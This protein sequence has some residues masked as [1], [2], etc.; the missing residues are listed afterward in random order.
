MHIGGMGGMVLGGDVGIPKPKSK[1]DAGTYTRGRYEAARTA[2]T[3]AEM[4]GLVARYHSTHF[5]WMGHLARGSSG[6]AVASVLSYTSLE[7]WVKAKPVGESADPRNRENGG[8]QGATQEMRYQEQNTK[9]GIS[10]MLVNRELERN[11]RR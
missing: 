6:K 3:E 4:V 1:R 8:T 5:R 2:R 10:H 9:N 11:R 7:L